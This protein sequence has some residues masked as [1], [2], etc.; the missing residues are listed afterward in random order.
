MFAQT[1]ALVFVTSAARAQSQW[2]TL[3]DFLARGVRLNA[4]DLA[5][6]KRGETVVRALPTGDTRDVA[7]FGVVQIDVPRSTFVNRQRDAARA[8]RTATRTQ[9]QAFSNPAVASDVQTLDVTNDDLEEL[10]DCRPSSCNFKLPATDMERFRTMIGTAPNARARIAAEARQRVVEYVNDYRAH[11]NAA[12]AVYEDRGVVRSGDAL[13]ALLRDSSF[14]FSAIPSLGQHVVDY[15]RYVPPGANQMIFWSRDDM[16]HLRPILRI[17]HQ[18]IFDPP[19]RSDISLIV[20]KQIY[21]DHYFEAG[22]EVLA[23]VDRPAASGAPI[24]I[25]AVAFRRYR[26]DHLP[27]GGLLNIRGRV[28][29]GLRDNLIADLKRLK[30][31]TAADAAR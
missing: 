27:N 31:E 12:L 26:F 29:N 1:A 3:D 2:T 10:R 16:P 19:E 11:G 25:T 20:G 17:T 28:A 6:V 15:P 5:A 8:L 18:T 14:A 21:A 24:G 13:V 7:V 22:L 4:Q 9:V 23:A 30:T